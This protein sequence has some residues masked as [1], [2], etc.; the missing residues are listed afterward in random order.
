[1]LAAWPRSIPQ[2]L[3]LPSGTVPLAVFVFLL[4]VCLGNSTV[5][6]Q[7]VPG[8]DGLTNLA[9]LAAFVMGGLALVR[10]IPWAVALV[11][12]VVLC[13]VAA[14]VAADGALGRANT[15][16]PTDP[17]RLVGARRR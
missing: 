4:V 6:A 1:M 11:I 15:D 14:Y 2:R 16:D 9:L 13:P 17:L 10:R 5:A 12:V 7:W 3:R 8:T